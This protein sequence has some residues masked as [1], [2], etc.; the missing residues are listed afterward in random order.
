M[1]TWY[2][3]LMESWS[4]ETKGPVWDQGRWGGWRT[5]SVWTMLWRVKVAA[6]P[7]HEAIPA[8]AITPLLQEGSSLSNV[9]SNFKYKNNTR[10]L[11]NSYYDF[12]NI[13]NKFT[14]KEK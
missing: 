11:I 9:K 3:L 4:K 2:P 10:M 5:S 14:N 6:H 7:K 13:I 1:Y 12:W 8:K